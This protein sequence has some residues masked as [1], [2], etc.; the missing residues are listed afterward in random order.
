MSS[1]TYFICWDKSLSNCLDIHNQL[2]GTGIDYLVYNV[3]SIDIE[4]PHWMR[5][6]D[7]RYYSHFH[8]ALTDFSQTH[9]DVFIFNAGDVEF[10]DY[11]PYTKKIEDLFNSDQLIGAFAPSMTHDVFSGDG[12]SIVESTTHH[13]MTLSTHTNG[14]Y[15][16]L[17]R[18]IALQVLE[19]MDWAQ[20]IGS[21]DWNSVTSGWG[22]DT[23]YCALCVYLGRKI[24]RDSSLELHHQEGTS[25]N[26]DPAIREMYL[27]METFKIY[28]TTKGIDADRIQEIYDIMYDKVRTRKPLSVLDLY[29][30]NI[31]S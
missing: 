4:I 22:L 31:A 7:T 24:Y 5:V 29:S 12:S 26:E 28:C 16:S 20:S 21:V 2:D 23:A 6:P 27:V 8:R 25:Y 10:E 11:E 1:K 13:G 19:Y 9:H 15:T 30:N 17:S 14:I 3:S 18:E